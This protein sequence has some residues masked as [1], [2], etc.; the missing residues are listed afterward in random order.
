[1]SALGARL[2]RLERAVERDPEEG[3]SLSDEEAAARIDGMLIRG[4]LDPDYRPSDEQDRVLVCEIRVLLATAVRRRR[5]VGIPDPPE[6]ARL[7]E[8]LADLLEVM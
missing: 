6:E 8:A 7:V 1:M 3:P 4:H 5:K 2:A